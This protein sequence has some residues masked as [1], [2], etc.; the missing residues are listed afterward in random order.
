MRVGKMLASAVAAVTMVAVAAPADAQRHRHR[1]HDRV[2]GGDVLLGAAI[3]GGLIA[4]ISSAERRK[5]ERIEAERYYE[6]ERY[7]AEA[8]PPPAWVPNAGEAPAGE[9]GG[10]AD[11]AS[12]DAAAD[13]CAAAALYEGQSLARLVSV[14]AVD[15]VDRAGT[16]WTV[17][18]TLLLRDD[19]RSR[20]TERG[21][22]CSIAGAGAPSVRI[23]G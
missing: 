13:A 1:H 10:Y 6:A 7:E 4:L 15:S 5:R 8:A 18:G 19:Y 20:G 17:R 11:I 9:P 3:A 14:G 22:R 12:A 21:F 2:D 23:D 16:G